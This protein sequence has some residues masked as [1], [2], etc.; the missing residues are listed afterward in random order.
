[1]MYPLG[2]VIF[3]IHL[4][5]WGKLFGKFGLEKN[6]LDLETNSSDIHDPAKTGNK[7]RYQILAYR[8]VNVCSQ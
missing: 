8:I 6:P 1:M 7:C 4:L 3:Q 2:T 5:Y